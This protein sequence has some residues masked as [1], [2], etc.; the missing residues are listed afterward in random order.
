MRVIIR[1]ILRKPGYPL[2]KQARATELVM[3]QAEV[4]CR[5]WSG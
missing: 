4:L 5:E 3:E 1:R 2:D